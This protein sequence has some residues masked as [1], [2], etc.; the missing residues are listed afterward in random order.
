MKASAKSRAPFSPDNADRRLCA[1][2]LQGAA[3]CHWGPIATSRARGGPERATHS[4]SSILHPRS[5][6]P[7]QL[8]GG[9]QTRFGAGPE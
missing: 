2:A 4:M 5:L 6:P 8:A 9:P 3:C 1:A 7:A